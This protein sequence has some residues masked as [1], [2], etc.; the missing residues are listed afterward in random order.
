MIMIMGK[1][2]DCIEFDAL[3]VVR[4]KDELPAPQKL[5]APVNG[6]SLS[7]VSE[8]LAYKNGLKKV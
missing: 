6:I 4:M 3:E 8:R 7:P 5:S 1:K 2:N